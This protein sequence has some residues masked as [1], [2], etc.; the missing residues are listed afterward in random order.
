VNPLDV[1]YSTQRHDDI[2]EEQR[3]L[4]PLKL[5]VHKRSRVI[6]TLTKNTSIGRRT[7][8]LRREALTCT[9]IQL[10]LVTMELR[11]TKINIYTPTNAMADIKPASTSIKRPFP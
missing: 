6:C 1:R 10:M 7:S 9:T 11:L 8:V 2:E 4:F 5:F 3:K